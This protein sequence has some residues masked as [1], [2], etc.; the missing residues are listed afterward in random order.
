VLA[1]AMKNFVDILVH[2]DNQVFFKLVKFRKS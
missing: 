1:H 2:P